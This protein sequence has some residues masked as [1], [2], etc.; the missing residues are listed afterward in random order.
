[1]PYIET[2]FAIY[3]G[4]ALGYSPHVPDA[5]QAVVGCVWLFDIFG[6]GGVIGVGQHVS[7]VS[8]IVAMQNA[9]IRPSPVSR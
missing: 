7:P 9:A 1:M 4:S 2:E 5:A 3:T 8:N 6:V